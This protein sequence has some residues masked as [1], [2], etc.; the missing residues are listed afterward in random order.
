[1]SKSDETDQILIHGVEVHY[2]YL[3]SSVKL[4]QER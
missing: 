3:G 4:R 2:S 1:M